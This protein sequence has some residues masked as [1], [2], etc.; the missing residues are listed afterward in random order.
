MNVRWPKVV[1]P[2]AREGLI[3][4]PMLEA[5]QLL[6]ASWLHSGL[7]PSSGCLVRTSCRAVGG[8]S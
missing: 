5:W 4:N 2:F 1:H 8:G 7:A 3:G 6:L